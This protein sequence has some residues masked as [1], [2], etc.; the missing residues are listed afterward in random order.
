VVA[1]E[2]ELRVALERVAPGEDV[3]LDRVVDHELRRDE[4]VDL[5]GVA[6]QVFHGVAHRGEVDDGRHPGE[7]LHQHTRGAVGD[8]VLRL[9]FG[10]PRRDPLDLLGSDELA[11][12]VA[13]QILQ[14]H[15]QRVRQAGDVVLLLEGVQPEDLE[16]LVAYRKFGTC[17]E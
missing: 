5:R 2:L 17:S 3:H 1:L 13:Q 12:L 6:A 9:S 8:L 7:V 10:V 4:R 16:V 11:V 15:L 14:Q